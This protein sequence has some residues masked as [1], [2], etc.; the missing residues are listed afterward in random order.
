M[1]PLLISS[2]Q[3]GRIKQ[4]VRLNN[5]RERD[6][7]QCTVVEGVREIACA[8]GAGLMPTAAYICPP[9]LDEVA[10]TSILARLSQLAAARQTAVYHVTPEVY[11]KISYREG[12]GGILLVL[13][14]FGRSLAD[15]AL[16]ERPLLVMI[17]GGE[18][19]GNL[20]AILRT[21]DA[22][23]V[24]AVIFCDADG[25]GGISVLRGTDMY[26]PNVVRASLGALFTVPVVATTAAEAIDWLA[27]RGIPILAA[28]PEGTELY[29]A[30][31]LCQPTAIVMGS[32]A[33]GLSQ[34]WLDA[35]AHRVVIPMR[36]QV[37]SLNLSVS[38][39]LLVYEAV[40]Q[41]GLPPQSQVA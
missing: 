2:V 36:G 8:L 40:R 18:K 24:D 5:R 35:A 22:A 15:L 29:T 30:V 1:E 17:E 27:V 28:T 33:H 23:G 4:V 34:P 9:L 14:Y 31:D 20:G 26:N 16:P 37:D 12:S 11:A 38:T 25:H 41:R 13:P 19:P 32:E 21:A 3:N 7:A 39:A 6:A 10:A